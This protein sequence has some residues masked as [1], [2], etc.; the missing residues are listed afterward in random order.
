M[1]LHLT[2][3]RLLCVALLWLAPWWQPA[4]AAAGDDRSVTI[5]APS[6]AFSIADHV[7][8]DGSVA[9]GGAITY[10]MWL[11][12]TDALPLANVAIAALA[13]RY[14]TTPA[15]GAG[16]QCSPAPS[17]PQQTICRAAIATLAVGAAYT[18]SLTL[19]LAPQ[20]PS[21][22]Q[23]ILLQATATADDVVCGACGYAWCSTPLVQG[24][25]GNPHRV[26]LPI[27]FARTP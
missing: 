18:L 15:P 7:A 12:N 6:F 25:G 21:D 5:E 9:P 10:T 2:A 27:L 13:P 16:W 17:D 19:L 14:T 11:T 23:E 3:I 4:T 26:L 24:S 22:Q 8:P 1:N 20:I